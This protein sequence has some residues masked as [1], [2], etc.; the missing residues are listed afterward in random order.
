VGPGLS[1]FDLVAA[2][3]ELAAAPDLGSRPLVLLTHGNGP[4]QT[5]PEAEAHWLMMQKRIALLSTSSILVRADNAGYAIQTEAVDLTAEA[6]R[7][8]IAAVRAKAPL[9][10]CAATPLPNLG[11]TCLDPS[12]SLNE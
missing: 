12:G 11:G 7:L 3:A 10:A 6:F 1:D 4:P 8:V 9:P 5:T 2:R